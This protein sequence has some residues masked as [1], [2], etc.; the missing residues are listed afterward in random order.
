MAHHIFLL[1][2]A[3]LDQVFHIQVKKKAKVMGLI[4]A[5]HDFSIYFF[6]ILYYHILL[7][8]LES[9]SSYTGAF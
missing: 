3:G 1:G 4:W 2:I 9:S 5:L 7:L 8:F 6:P